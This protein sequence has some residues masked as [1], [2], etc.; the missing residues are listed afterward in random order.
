MEPTNRD[1][2]SFLLVF[3]LPNAKEKIQ[4]KNNKCINPTIY[5]TNLLKLDWIE[6]AALSLGPLLL[7]CHSLERHIA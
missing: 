4:K 2:L 3:A 6:E 7:P 5:G 1:E